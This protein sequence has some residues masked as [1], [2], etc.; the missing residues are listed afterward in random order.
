[1][2]SEV[3]KKREESGIALEKD[4]RGVWGHRKEGYEMEVRKGLRGPVVIETFRIADPKL[5]REFEGDLKRTIVFDGPKISEVAFEFSQKGSKPFRIATIDV[6]KEYENV[7]ESRQLDVESTIIKKIK[8]MGVTELRFEVGFM[9]D[10]SMRFGGRGFGLISMDVSSTG[11]GAGGG[12]KKVLLLE[13]EYRTRIRLHDE[14][15][16]MKGLLKKIG[17]LV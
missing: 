12:E 14:E 6:G 16:N 1:M 9:I 15:A 2:P 11:F 3:T 7:K 10:E 8:R 13:N 4:E 17:E 5:I